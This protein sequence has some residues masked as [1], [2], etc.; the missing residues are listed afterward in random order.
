MVIYLFFGILL[1]VGLYFLALGFMRANPGQVVN[2]LK[3]AAFVVGAGAI[4]FLVVSGRLT[5]ALF[6]VPVLLP[7]LMRLRTFARMAKAARG[8]SGGQSSTVAT[9]SLAMELDHDNGEMDGT[10]L[11]GPMEGRRLSDLDPLLLIDLYRWCC[12]HDSQSARLLEAYLDRTLGAEWREDAGTN[13][14]DDEA[15]SSTGMTE[16]EA[17]QILGLEPGADANSIRT[18]Y[19]SLMQHAHPDR[20]GSAYLAAK[21]NQAKDM[22]L[23]QD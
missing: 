2:G 3:L 23:S 8:P 21:I 10:V 12:E 20:G 7:W 18:A 11:A 5:W 4:V 6:M 9:D 19:R 13:F 1:A 17:Y 15:P 22:L 16:E 14:R